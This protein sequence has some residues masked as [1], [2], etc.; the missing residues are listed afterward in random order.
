MCDRQNRSKTDHDINEESD[1][2]DSQ[3]SSGLTCSRFIPY[4]RV[5]NSARTL[6]I[7]EQC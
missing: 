7:G 5:C 6:P 2:E 4:Y 1:Y 3:L